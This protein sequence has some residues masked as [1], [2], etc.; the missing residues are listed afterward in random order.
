MLALF[1]YEHTAEGID[2]KT[3]DAIRK[4]Y[5]E[6]LELAIK[7]QEE[8]QAAKSDKSKYVMGIH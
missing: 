3:R 8:T 4:K 7:I 5:T 2:E 6:T 1:V